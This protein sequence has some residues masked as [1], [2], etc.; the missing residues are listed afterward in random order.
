MDVELGQTGHLVYSTVHTTGVASTIRRMVSSFEPSER[1][2]RAYALME[3][4]RLIVT[5]TLVPKIGGGRQAL[6]EFMPFTEEIRERLLSL[7]FDQWPVE[8]MNMV[9]KYGKTMERSARE[10]FEAGLIE[11]RYYLL[12]AQGTKAMQERKDIEDNNTKN[13]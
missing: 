8:L 2:E 7:S 6:R 5:Q 10:A 9:P 11:R 3:T 4:M 13:H 1:S 12:Y